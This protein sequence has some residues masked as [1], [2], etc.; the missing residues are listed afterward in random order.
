[1]TDTRDVR[2]PS[3]DAAR[4]DVGALEVLRATGG[5]RVSFLH[6]L[7]TSDIASLGPGEGRRAL[8]LTV[9]AQVVADLAVCVRADD[10]R[11]VT[12]PGLA[13]PTAAA[14]A[15]YAV[16][17]DVAF[18]PLPD[19]TPR[20]LFGPRAAERLA[21]A[22]VALPAGFADRPPLAHGEVAGPT[23]GLWV[24]RA[25]AYGSDG[26]WLFGEAPALAGLDAS[27]EAAGVAR[28]DPAAAEVLRIRAGE[29]LFGAEITADHFPTEVGL[30]AAIDYGKGCF[31]GQEPVVRV[32]DRG[33]INWRLVGL[34]VRGEG[35]PARGDALEADVKA[36]AGRVTSA[37]ALPGEPA[38]ALALLHVSV[39][40]G[41]VVR[42][43]HEGATLEADVVPAAASQAPATSP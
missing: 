17:D 2:L 43:K 10:V 3:E 8:L 40:L 12:P 4:V 13:A 25:R 15:R 14:L 24:V 35:V 39:P 1:M 31:L 9:K 42:V 34:R 32:R 7:L 20:G 18:E 21:A 41:A 26:F 23:G 37:A 27:L 19:L 22:G 11:L 33:H 6:R 16:M 29:P 28:L 36:K 38:V 30:E 5:D